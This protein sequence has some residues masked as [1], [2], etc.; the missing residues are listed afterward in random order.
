MNDQSD[1]QFKGWKP[2]RM[3][4]QFTIIHSAEMGD[5]VYNYLDLLEEGTEGLILADRVNPMCFTDEVESNKEIPFKTI[6]LG[7]LILTSYSGIHIQ[8]FWKEE[9]GQF[10]FAF[11]LIT[12]HIQN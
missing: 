4:L 8:S 7:L 6:S 2:G 3:S 5:H 10:K 9:H 1:G 11:S 12:Q